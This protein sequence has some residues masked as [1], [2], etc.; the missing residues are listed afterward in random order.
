MSVGRLWRKGGNLVNDAKGLLDALACDERVPTDVRV[1]RIINATSLFCGIL[2][3]QPL[4]FAD[5]FVLT[6]IQVAMVTYIAKAMGMPL[7]ESGAREVITTVLGVVGWGFIAQHG[8][9]GLYKLGVPYLG[10]I[11][12]IPLVYAA[13][14]AIGYGSKAVLEARANG[15]SLSKDAIEAIRRSA[16]E[17][18]K[19]AVQHFCVDALKQQLAYYQQLTDEM[20][21]EPVANSEIQDRVFAAFEEAK[22]EIDIMSPWA[23]FRVASGLRS[24]MERALHR[25]VT[26]KILYGLHEKSDRA[27]ERLNRTT[28]VIETMRIWFRPYGD[29]FRARDIAQTRNPSGTHVKLLICD[30]SYYLLGSYN[31]LSFD[32]DY[33]DGGREEIVE[34]SRN[35]ELLRHY[36]RLYFS[37]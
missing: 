2:A 34:L 32:G 9:I 22:Y 31:F 16:F 37:F 5:M 12:T 33:Q 29:R 10:A 15:V 21:N 19:R 14:Y 6:P 20:K 30:E 27:R 36:R 35:V 17:E 3:A 11:S 26:I 25:G 24:H 1:S 4:P 28:E 13:T 7:S 18:G 8:I 23:N